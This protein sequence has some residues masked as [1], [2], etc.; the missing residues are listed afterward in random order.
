M[1][2]CGPALLSTHPTP[3]YQH[4]NHN[5]ECIIH[6]CIAWSCNAIIIII[7]MLLISCF[8]PISSYFNLKIFTFRHFWVVSI[9]Q[10]LPNCTV[11]TL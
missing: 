11:I 2:L 9:F 3:S 4:Q 7:I 6:W 5:D 8:W 1:L 10:I